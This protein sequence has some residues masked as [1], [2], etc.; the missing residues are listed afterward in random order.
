MALF[1][2]HSQ[3][4]YGARFNVNSIPNFAII[5]KENQEEKEYLE[6]YG[7]NFNEFLYDALIYYSNSN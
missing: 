1:I 3:N 6:Q 5:Y 4:N 7:T 2:R